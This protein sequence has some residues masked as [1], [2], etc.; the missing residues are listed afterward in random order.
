MAFVTKLN[1]I[2]ENNMEDGEDIREK[3]LSMTKILRMELKFI[4]LII[5]H[6][7]FH[8]IH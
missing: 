6:Y 2:M 3:R 8:I 5:I 7:I 1:T 4:D